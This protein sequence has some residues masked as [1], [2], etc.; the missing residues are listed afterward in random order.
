MPRET[1]DQRNSAPHQNPA[2]AAL[3]HPQPQ[4]GGGA[5]SNATTCCALDARLPACFA[6]ARRNCTESITSPGCA[7]NASPRSR[8]HRGF[9]PNIA[10]EASI[11]SS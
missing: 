6:F 8:T 11:W 2:R 9:S 1:V 3:L 5:G 4:R 10:I 7:S